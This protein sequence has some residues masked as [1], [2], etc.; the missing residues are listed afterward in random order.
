VGNAANIVK[1]QAW[2]I[3]H[4]KVYKAENDNV[5]VKAAHRTELAGE[6]IVRDTSRFVKRRVR[7]RPAR[8]V[9][10]MEKRETKAKADYN[11]RKTAHEKPELKKAAYR[12]A[13]KARNRAQFQDRSK[14]A[15][16]T[17]GAAAKKTALAVKKAG[18][19]LVKFAASHPM[20]A[21]IIALALLLVVILQSCIGGALTVGNGVLGA[22]GGTSY[23]AEDSDINEASIAYS[24]WEIDLLMEALNAET[25]HPG[26]DEYK[27]FL[28]PIGH[29]PHALLSFLT[30]KYDDFTFAAIESALRDIFNMQ[31][32]LDFTEIIE[33][34]S[35]EETYIDDDGEEQTETI[36]Y[37]YYILEV[38]LTAQSFTDILDSLLTTQ[39]ERDRYDVYNIIKGN[40]QYVGSPFPFNWLPYVTSNFG[41][42]V[43]PITGVKDF[44]RGID[45]ALPEGT[46]IQAGGAGVVVEATTH[47]LYGLTIVIDYGNGVMARYSHCSSLI[48]SVGQTAEAGDTIALVGSTGAVTGPHLDLEVLKDGE[49]MNPLYFVVIP[50]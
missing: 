46:Q 29:D 2:L 25:S 18:A 39:D 43:H 9:R 10:K 33:V 28:D 35:Y 44:H 48:L 37:D 15:A 19:A 13:R 4:G 40:R 36:Y 20:I 7:T 45:I 5:G 8:Q 21:L 38:T 41:W 14:Q 12:N 16:K 50:F 6:R 26:Y 47:S 30:A 31:Y 42:R 23:L 1:S 32:N 3:A 24:E 34:R 17:T 11:Y 22:I 49:L 27:Y